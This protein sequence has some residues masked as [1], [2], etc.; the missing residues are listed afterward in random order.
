MSSPAPA[1]DLVQ[2]GSASAAAEEPLLNARELV[3]ELGRLGA[4]HWTPDAVRQW[5]REEPACPIARAG[6]NGQPHKYRILAVLDWLLARAR[7]ERSKGHSRADGAEAA[8]VIEEARR[9]ARGE[10]APHFAASGA[11]AP[12]GEGAGASLALEDRDVQSLARALGVTPRKLAQA[13][14]ALELNVNRFRDPRSWKAH[15]EARLARMKADDMEGR[16]VPAPEVE[17]MLEEIVLAVRAALQ[18]LPS[19]LAPAIEACTD[20]FQR[21]AAIEQRADAVLDHLAGTQRMSPN[22]LLGAKP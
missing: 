8:A 4:G 15:E 2:G 14:A 10:L 21:R 19:Q 18:A 20:A 12:G 11:P 7:K 22:A 6:V 16:L 1:L 9:K 17:S 3:S 13:L 5:T